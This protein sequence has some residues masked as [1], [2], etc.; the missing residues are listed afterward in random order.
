MVMR[1]V[2]TAGL[3]A[4]LSQ[5]LAEVREGG[6]V[7]V[8]SHGHPVAELSPLAGGGWLGIQEPERPVSDLAKMQIPACPKKIP[9]EDILRQDRGR[10]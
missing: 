10:R 6:T 5:Y 4:K 1:Y 8:T 7:Y 9:A 3:K 2:S